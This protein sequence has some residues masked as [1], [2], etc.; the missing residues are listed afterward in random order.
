[1]YLIH[2]YY[3]GRDKGPVSR[4][5]DCG[6]PHEEGR[7]PEHRKGCGIYSG[8]P[9]LFITAADADSYA[10]EVLR[11]GKGSYAIEDADEGQPEPTADCNSADD[12]YAAL[13]TLGACPYCAQ[14]AI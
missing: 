13:A 2:P 11:Y 7:Y 5:C 12:H 10:Q 4:G 6:V 3:T 8:E 14:E 1:M 9:L